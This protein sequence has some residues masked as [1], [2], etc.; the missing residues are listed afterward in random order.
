MNLQR[1]TVTCKTNHVS[2]SQAGILAEIL[3]DH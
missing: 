1:G 2:K 3:Y